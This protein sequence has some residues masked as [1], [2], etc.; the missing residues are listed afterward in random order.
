MRVKIQDTWFEVKVGQPIMVELTDEDKKNM[1][2][3]MTA[4]DG[5]K[6]AVFSDEEKLTREEMLSWMDR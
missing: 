3:M 6:Y 2:P 1:L 5:D 4:S